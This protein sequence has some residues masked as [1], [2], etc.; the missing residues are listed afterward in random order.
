M[1]ASSLGVKPIDLAKRMIDYGVHPPTLVGAGCVYYG[2]SLS[3]AMLFE[4]TESES[5]K[6][7]DYLV[8]VVRK[9]IDEARLIWLLWKRRRTMRCR[10]S[11]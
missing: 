7:L 9:I 11:C 6:D 10:K 1:D 2:D 8:E 3:G 4:P 5:K